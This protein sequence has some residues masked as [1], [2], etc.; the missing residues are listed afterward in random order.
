MLFHGISTFKVNDVSSDNFKADKA[1]G[2]KNAAGYTKF[3]N[4][5]VIDKLFELTDETDSADLNQFKRLLKQQ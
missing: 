5:Y 2:I 1:G 4:F 3:L